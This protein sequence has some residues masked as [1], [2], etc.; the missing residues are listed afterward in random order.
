MRTTHC[1]KYISGVVTT[2]KYFTKMIRCYALRDGIV[3]L[4]KDS[5]GNAYEII[6]R[7]AKYA[8]YINTKTL[9]RR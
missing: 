5:E 3:S 6:I 1:F 7:P 9:Q 8:K 4:I 2:L